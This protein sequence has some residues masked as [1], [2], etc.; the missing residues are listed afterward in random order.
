MTV[1]ARE[2]TGKPGQPRILASRG[3]PGTKLH[4]YHNGSK[5]L[6]R[7]VSERRRGS[8]H[9]CGHRCP[10][11]G[12]IPNDAVRLEQQQLLEAMILKGFKGRGRRKA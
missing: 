2:R 10:Y 7:T 12:F 8:Q 11:C 5:V 6:V 3:G 4:H 9:P 1:L